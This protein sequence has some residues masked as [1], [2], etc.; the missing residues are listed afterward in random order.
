MAY[1]GESLA[2]LHE[3]EERLADAR[4]RG[5]PPATHDDETLRAYAAAQ[6]ELEHA[7]GYSWRSRLESILRGLGF[8]ERT[9]TATCA[10]SPA[11][12]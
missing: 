1:V 7:G 2:D 9:S 5:W 8:D 3:T 12:S 4:A 10:R 6:A 11:A